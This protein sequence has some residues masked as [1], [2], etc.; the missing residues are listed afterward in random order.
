M[1]TLTEE[2]NVPQGYQA[3]HLL[4]DRLTEKQTLESAG[5]KIVPYAQLTRPSDLEKLQKN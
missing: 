3:I 4:Q 1:Q 2:F 5:T